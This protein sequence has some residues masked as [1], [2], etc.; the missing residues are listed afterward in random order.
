MDPR[1]PRGNECRE[2]FYGRLRDESL[3]AEVLYSLRE[4]Q[5]LIEQRCRRYNTVRSRSA[6]G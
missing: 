2:S 6:L 3:N 1:S 4:A 5:I